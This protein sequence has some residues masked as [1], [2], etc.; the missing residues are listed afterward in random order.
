MADLSRK[1][2]VEE[3]KQAD[4]TGMLS[5]V[6]ASLG[7]LGQTVK[8]QLTLAQQ[9]KEAMTSMNY[10]LHEGIHLLIGC[11]TGTSNVVLWCLT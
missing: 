10:A 5:A 11:A 7:Q 6:H 9:G 3:A 2:A 8:A 1:L 4:L